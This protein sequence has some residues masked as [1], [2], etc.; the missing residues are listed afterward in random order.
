VSSNYFFV[1]SS[2]AEM[3]CSDD[4]D[5]V[6]YLCAKS[7]SGMH[8][9]ANPVCD[10]VVHLI[11]GFVCPGSQEGAEQQ[12]AC[13]QCAVQHQIPT[14]GHRFLS[15]WQNLVKSSSSLSSLPASVSSLPANGAK[16]KRD[17]DEEKDDD[18]TILQEIAA[19]ETSLREVSQNL[20]KN[21]LIISEEIHF[22]FDLLVRGAVRGTKDVIK[23]QKD[24]SVVATNFQDLKTRILDLGKSYIKGSATKTTN[25]QW[26]I[27]HR[28]ETSLVG[29]VR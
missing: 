5:D 3:D 27:T 20:L 26:S 18:L 16:R 14:E 11:C 2:L 4:D 22:R 1:S 19:I 21:P 7:C 28:K 10:R 8:G 23:K 13:Y 25:D 17:E 6:C 12:V 9:C 29:S 15:V 24:L